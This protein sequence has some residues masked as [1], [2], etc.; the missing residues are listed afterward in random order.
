MSRKPTGALS[1]Y[2]EKQRNQALQRLACV[3]RFRDARR[4]REGLVKEWLPDLIEELRADFPALKIGKTQIYAWHKVYVRPADLVKLI[5]KRGSDRRSPAAVLRQAEDAAR[6]AIVHWLGLL[7]DE[8][9]G[10]LST[11]AALFGGAV[12]VARKG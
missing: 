1:A 7:G 5:D 9:I 2:S 4:H 12:K 6:R 8:H 10:A 11:L 3:E